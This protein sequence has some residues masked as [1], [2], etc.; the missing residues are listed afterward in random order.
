MTDPNA[1]APLGEPPVAVAVTAAAE[2][3]PVLP[4]LGAKRGLMALAVFLGT[5]LLVAVVAGV[6]VGVRRLRGGGASTG[7]GLQMDL[8]PTIGATF[9]GTL[10]GGLAVLRLVHRSA[11]GWSAV[12]WRPARIS[13]CVGAV[14][15]GF[16]LV[17]VFVLLGRALPATRT[18]GP[19]ASLAQAGV[20][21]R[22]A[23]AALAFVVAPP[24]DELVLRGALDAGRLR[25]GR[26]LVAGALTTLVFVG[27]HVTEIGAY[28][29]AWIAIGLLG[30][31]AL[32]ARL[33]TGSL[34]PAIALHASYNL[35]L[36]LAVYLQP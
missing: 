36:V 13:A 11:G 1:I 2:T 14:A 32:R 6:W 21:A 34:L 15:Q 22:L 25:T 10:I 12:G 35:G 30:V 3:G 4:V 8:G 5:Q 16:G 9:V 20:W 31:L 19:L 18:L 17:G 28:W 7:P 33:T 23:W 24:V 26:P 27:L 29:P